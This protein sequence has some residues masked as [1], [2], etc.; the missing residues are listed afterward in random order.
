M[1]LACSATHPC[2]P[3][4]WRVRGAGAA[5]VS[6]N[7]RRN[8][9]QRSARQQAIRLR[10]Q[11]QVTPPQSRRCA[12]SKCHASLSPSWHSPAGQIPH[13][14][15]LCNCTKRLLQLQSKRPF[16][17]LQRL[18]RDLCV[19]NRHGKRRCSVERPSI[20]ELS[21]EKVHTRVTQYASSGSVERVAAVANT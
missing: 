1:Q 12:R 14:R 18:R 8:R 6:S 19:L 21:L 3:P 20:M 17:T 15:I 13:T 7:G 5:T 10:R 9:D 2:H 4:P 16:R 11:L